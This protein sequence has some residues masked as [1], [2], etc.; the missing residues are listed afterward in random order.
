MKNLKKI[1]G[2]MLCLVMFMNMGSPVVLAADIS[3]AEEECIELI[4]DYEKLEKAWVE[5][6]VELNPKTYRKFFEAAQEGHHNY[7]G[8][9]FDYSKHKILK[10]GA[11]RVGGIVKAHTPNSFL[12]DWMNSEQACLGPTE[13]T[14][15]IRS[16]DPTALLGPVLQAHTDYKNHLNELGQKF[17]YVGKV[18]EGQTG[19]DE[20]SSDGE[21]EEEGRELSG[22]EAL[23]AKAAA[24][25]S[26]A[27]QRQMEIDSSLVAIDLMFASL[28]E[29]RLAFV[30]HV[31]FQCT[32][33]FLEKYRKALGKLRKLIQ[34]LPDQ[35]RDASVVK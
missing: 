25:G 4:P 17:N 35:L 5:E 26:I 12:I 13:I 8:C 9:L 14:D 32:L 16:T 19:E 34:P 20:D 7:V 31:H 6:G 22:A 33:K 2:L 11:N 1:I 18:R 21:S 29:L 23:I 3:E 24:A 15:I 27:R 30:M 10:T 28:K